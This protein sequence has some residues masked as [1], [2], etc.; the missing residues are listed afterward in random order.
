MPSLLGV[1]IIAL[2]VLAIARRVDVRLVLFTAALALAGSADLIQLTREGAADGRITV[3]IRQFLVTFA[4]EKF[5]V[6]ICTAMGF[7]YVLRHTGCDQHLVHLLVRPIQRVRFLLIPGTVVVGFLV[8]IP[9][10]SQTS[11][12]VTIGP[13]LIPLLQ[14]AR[15]SPVTTGAALLL[16]SSLGGELLNPGAP[17]LLTV[18]N[19]T[20]EKR[21]SGEPLA[22][23]ADCVHHVLPLNLLHLAVATAVFWWLSLL[24]EKRTLTDAPETKVDTFRVDLARAMVPLLPFLLLVLTSPPLELLP[25]PRDWLVGAQDADRFNSRLIGAA[26]LIGTAAATLLTPRSA[27]GAA[28][29]FF[30]G[31]GYAFTHIISLIVVANCFGKGVEMTG[32]AAHLGQLIDRLPGFLMP[33]AGFLSLGFAALCGSGMAATQSLFGFFVPPARALGVDPV[34]VGAVVSLGAAAGR[35]MSPVA[36]VTLM[37]ANLTG[38]E[39]VALG[40]RVAGPLLAGVFA[41]VAVSI[42]TKGLFG[43]G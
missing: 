22:T 28:R 25:V 27:L 7:A 5:V 23:P 8:N 40:R 2:A 30:D 43:T 16:G 4:D 11:T 26:M 38:T 31:A 10:I 20:N 29:A 3:I 36:A 18:V 24:A 32:L 14:T 9:I 21:A 15:I 13:V 35:T 41:V 39:P 6:P 37:C 1:L 34:A 19:V 33:L 42:L 17:E 12:A